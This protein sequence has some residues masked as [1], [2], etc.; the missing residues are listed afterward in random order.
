V[1]R[2][3]LIQANIGD[4][5]KIAAEQGTR[6]AMSEVLKRYLDLSSQAL[7]ATPS[8]D[9]FVWPETAY[10]GLFRQPDNANERAMEETLDRFL[11]PVK[12]TFIFGGYDRDRFGTEYNSLFF[13]HTPWRMTVAYHKN[14]LL[15][16][17]ETLPFSDLFPSMKTWFP[18]MGF[19]GRGPGPE[20][21]EVQNLE[22]KTFRFA[23]SICY[24][25]L[26]PEHSI[27]G[28]LE[29]AD[30]LLNVTNDSWFGPHGEPYLHLA[31]TRFRTVET[32]LPLVRSTNTGISVWMD[33]LGETRKST[34]LFEPAVLQAEIRLRELPPPPFMRIGAILGP[35]WF[36]RITQILSLLVL[37]FLFQRRRLKRIR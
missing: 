10:P 19:F 2:L 26:V 37:G 29:G 33:P 35:N 16:F 9:A 8:P 17:G 25:G 30:A 6:D 11:A 21:V 28:A 22:G 36:V 7:R 12:S 31:L 18:T 20:A 4:F 15:M 1:F 14:I 23:P 27:Q 34:P 32:R 24:E 5:L 13:H 3:A